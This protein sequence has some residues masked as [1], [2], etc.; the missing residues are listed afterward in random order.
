MQPVPALRCST[1]SQS[2][3]PAPATS[4]ATAS[5]RYGLMNFTTEQEAAHI[6][7]LYYFEQ[8]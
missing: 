2:A 1:R 8:S 5:A 7:R 6:G 4:L 3:S